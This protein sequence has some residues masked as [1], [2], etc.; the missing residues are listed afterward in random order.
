M[1]LTT[2]FLLSKSSSDNMSSSTIIGVSDKLFFN[3]LA[4]PNLID[5]VA[6][7][8]WPLEENSDEFLSFICISK[9]SLWGPKKVDP[10]DISLSKF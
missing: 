10:F 5:S 7:L 1:K 6:V 2:V 9:S 8:I 4:S 3:A